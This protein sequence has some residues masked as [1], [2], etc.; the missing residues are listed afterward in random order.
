M[1]PDQL[2]DER[3]KDKMQG[4]H[5][6][7]KK[8]DEFVA[9]AD[10]PHQAKWRVAFT[11][12][13]FFKGNYEDL[14]KGAGKISFLRQKPL[15]CPEPWE[16]EAMA[17]DAPLRDKAIIKSLR[18]TGMR[19]ASVAK[20][21]WSHIFDELFDSKAGGL[22][23]DHVRPVHI[24]LTAT[25]LKGK[26]T[27]VEQHAFLTPE[28]TELLLEYKRMREQRGETVSRDSMLFVRDRKKGKKYPPLTRKGI[29]Y[30]IRDASSRIDKDYSAHDFRR[31]TQTLFERARIQPNWVRKLLGRK[32][33]GEEDPYSR[34]KI[35]DLRNEFAKAMPLITQAKTTEMQ[36]A[37]MEKMKS[38]IADLEDDREILHF[39]YEALREYSPEAFYKIFGKGGT[40]IFFDAKGNPTPEYYKFQKVAVKR[41]KAEEG[42]ET[43]E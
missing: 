9:N 1:S 36:S 23:W 17:R 26:Y 28:T 21:R 41:M 43:T 29:G 12:K 5:E 4:T 34:P 8:L 20:L 32:I 6:A 13:S 22:T 14:S 24:R 42:K 15:R 18:D 10:F 27:E 35:D 3:R 7:E 11:V 33:R 19:E 37:E 2:L 38:Q 30:V 39:I 40:S 31:F 16:I 25:E